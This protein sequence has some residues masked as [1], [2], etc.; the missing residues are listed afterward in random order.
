MSPKKYKQIRVIVA[1]FVGAIVSIATTLDS[2]LLALI[3]VVTGMLFLILVRSKTRIKIDKREKI[4]REKAAQTTYAIF[5]PTIGVGALL[6]LLPSHAGLSVFAKEEF[7]QFES[8]G[9]IFA[10]LAL[11]LIALYSISYYFLNRKYGGDEE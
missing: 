5:A 7:I 8:L 11:F 9:T 10:Y 1:L 2:Y 6:L 4:I 3:G